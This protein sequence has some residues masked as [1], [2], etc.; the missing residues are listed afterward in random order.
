[1]TAARQILLSLFVLALAGGGWWLFQGGV[2]EGDSA[3]TAVSGSPGGQSRVQGGGGP[4]P[5]GGGGGPVLVVTT[6]VQIDDAGE[7]VRAIGTLGAAQSVTL[8]PEVTG[9]VA[10]IDFRPGTPVTAGDVLIRLSDADQRVEVERATIAR[11][12]ARSALERA[13]K[14]LASRT[15]TTVAV[16]DAKSALQ[17]A[18]IDLKVAEL[19]LAKR[20]IT[21]PFSGVIG[22]T[23]LSVGDLVTPTRAIATLDDMSTVTVAF[24]VPERVSARVTVGEKVIATSPALPDQTFTGRVSALDNRVDAASRTLKVEA[25]L[26]NEADVLRAG[27][28]VIVLLS[29]P[30]EARPMV[31]SLAV[32][33]DRNGSYVWKV[34]GDEARRVPI[35]V[36]ARNSGSVTVAADLQAGDPVVIEG[37][38]RIREGGK[39]AASGDQTP[40]P[41]AATSAA[42]RSGGDG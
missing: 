19:A 21:A 35:R 33:W 42:A 20:S 18:E 32:Q 41:A 23:D 30:G 15:V 37:L 8:F 13:E 16:S 5:G 11:D 9:T 4:G 26:P 10:S 24:V 22:L 1:M 27:M 39:V 2:L 31:P 40:A 14:L 12:D 29:F 25:E 7:T 3:G 6:P 38:Q 28:S 36:I 34:A 17:K